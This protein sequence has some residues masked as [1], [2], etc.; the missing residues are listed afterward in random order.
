MA[1]ETNTFELVKSS[2]L[3][4]TITGTVGWEALLF[5]KPV[6]AFGDVYY[7]KLSFVKKCTEIEKLPILVKEQLD[8][9]REVVNKF[10]T[11]ENNG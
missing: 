7:N 6:I 1:P 2:K 10:Q 11:T 9:M 4:T 5:K 8:M 3:V